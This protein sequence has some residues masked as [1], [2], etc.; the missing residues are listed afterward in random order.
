MVSV[1]VSQAQVYVL[2]PQRGKNEFQGTLHRVQKQ[3]HSL[4]HGDD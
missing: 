2:S 4:P 1:V 3:I